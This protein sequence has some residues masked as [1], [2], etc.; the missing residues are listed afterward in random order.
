M[1]GFLDSAEIEIPC[2]NCQRKTKKTIVWIKSN[3]EF[4]C[5]CGTT[6]KL[7]AEQFKR[8][9]AKAEKSF[10]DLQRTIKNLVK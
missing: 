7:E 10:S 3:K 8:E 4:T 1:A 9:I 5:A 2:E 6:I